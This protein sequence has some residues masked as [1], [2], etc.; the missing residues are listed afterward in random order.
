M[1]RLERFRLGLQSSYMC[2]V[3]FELFVLQIVNGLSANPHFRLL[4]ISAHTHNSENSTENGQ[5]KFEG[6]RGTEE[7]DQEGV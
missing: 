5:P 1:R 6:F 3:W 7:K 2:L 4:V